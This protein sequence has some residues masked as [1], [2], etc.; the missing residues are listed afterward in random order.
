MKKLLSKI[1]I[2]YPVLTFLIFYFTI[3]ATKLITTPAPFYDWDESIYAEVGREMINRGSLVP[4]WQYQTWLDKPPLVPL[5][6]GLLM[7]VTPFIQPEI[8]TRVVTLFIATIALFF[9]Y[10]LYYRVVKDKWLATL[11]V[12]LTSFTSII[13]Q[14]G[15]VLNIDIFL[16]IGWLGYVLFYEQFWLSLFF[17]TIAVL[18]KSLLGFYASGIMSLY[19]FYLFITKQI[20][21]KQLLKEAQKIII[22]VALMLI[23]YVVMFAIYGNAFI[24]QH[25]YESHFKRVTASIETHFGRREYYITLLYEYF[26]LFSFVSIV[27]LGIILW[28]WYKK[29]IKMKELLYALFLFPWF[30]FLNLTKTKIFWY[31]H[32]YIPQFAFLILY[33]ISLLK[34]VNK[35]IYSVALIL[36]F[37][38]LLHFYF[39]KQNVYS[40]QYA[41]KEPHHELAM[42]ANEQCNEMTMLMNPTER[43]KI[44]DLESLDLTITTTKWWGEHPSM[45]YYFDKKLNFLYKTTDFEKVLQQA[46]PKNCVTVTTDDLHFMKNQ[47]SVSLLKQFGTVYLYRFGVE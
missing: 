32:P 39:F 33:P 24:V 37:V 44:I 8:S 34:K 5:F 17:L 27:G 38:G 47:K 42:F 15:L 25:I 21:Q 16:L 30:L 2:H 3:F 29:Q 35:Y 23:W 40:V 18:S 12:V 45:V 43:K 26:G 19:F 46:T 11:I 41:T 36:I 6:Y 20:T 22:H 14:R 7:K 28:Q 13:L 31:S 10:M 4:L 9:V 1:K